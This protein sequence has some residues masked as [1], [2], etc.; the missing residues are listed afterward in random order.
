M[1][2]KSFHVVLDKT[3][4]MFHVYRIFPLEFFNI[5]NYF[6]IQKSKPDL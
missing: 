4:W 6:K 5:V 1:G 2:N 3:L